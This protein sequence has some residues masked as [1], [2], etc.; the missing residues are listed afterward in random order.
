MCLVS[1]MIYRHVF[2]VES[3]MAVLR[4]EVRRYRW[5][6]TGGPLAGYVSDDEAVVVTHAAGPGRKGVRRT[7]GVTISGEHA[8]LFCDGLRRESGGLI[9]YVGDWHS[10]I[11]RSV[12]FSRQDAA[13]MVLMATF[14]GS[15]TANPI[16]V[17][18]SRVTGRIAAYA[19][20]GNGHLDPVP[21]S[22]IQAIPA[23]VA[24]SVKRR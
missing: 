8:Q 23:D 21:C 24:D 9:D 5:K 6:E 12:Q 7:F 20:N 11:G 15:P 22:V 3:A 16:S 17:I 19:L 1:G 4:A 2:V 13:A 14:D 18:V 10:H